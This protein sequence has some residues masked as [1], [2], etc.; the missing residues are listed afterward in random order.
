MTAVSSAEYQRAWRARQG[1][2]T[3]QRGPAPTAEHGTIGAY[4]R[5]R[6]HGEPPCDPCR[7]AWNADQRARYAAK[8]KPE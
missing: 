5:H 4:R 2:R 8:K 3:G 1:A 6:R 7:E